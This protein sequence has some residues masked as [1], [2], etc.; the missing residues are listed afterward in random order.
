M[1]IRRE[2]SVADGRLL[3]SQGALWYT[4]SINYKIKWV[5]KLPTKRWQ[6]IKDKMQYCYGLTRMG[7]QGRAGRQLQASL[8]TN[9]GN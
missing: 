4:E 5:N 7:A 1:T 6:D 2:T 9:D 3:D 8:L